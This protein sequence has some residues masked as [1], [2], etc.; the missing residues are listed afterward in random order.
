VKRFFLAVFLRSALCVLAIGSLLSLLP[1]ALPIA[2]TAL[3]EGAL[4]SRPGSVSI[5]TADFGETL[6]WYQDNLDF[7]LIALRSTAPERTAVLERG[8]FFLEIT[9]AD[10]PAPMHATGDRSARVTSYPVLSLLVSDVDDEIERLEARG[11]EILELPEDDL[12][13][14]YRTAQIKDNG[15]HRIE[16]REPLG[17]P[18]SVNSNGH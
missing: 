5:R 18:A 9:E 16:L 12:D 6:R 1:A 11:V 4:S 2:D 8:S 14:S 3:A 7:R 10:H 13:G 17:S 15:R